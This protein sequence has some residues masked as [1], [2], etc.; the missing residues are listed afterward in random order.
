MSD[1]TYLENYE[2]LGYKVIPIDKN[3]SPVL[4]VGKTVVRIG[5]LSAPDAYKDFTNPKVTHGAV[6]CGSMFCKLD[7]NVCRKDK[8]CGSGIVVIDFDKF[9]DKHDKDTFFC[10]AKALEILVDNEF[11]YTPED[12]SSLPFPLLKTRSGG[13]HAWFKY[14]DS[15][16]PG[17]NRAKS[18]VLFYEKKPLIDIKSSH[19]YA[20]VPISG[21]SD[22]KWIVSPWDD[23]FKEEGL[24]TL[25]KV[26]PSLY[27]TLI[28][29]NDKKEENEEVEVDK[30]VEN[31]PPPKAPI[32]AII[33][34]LSGLPQMTID[35]REDYLRISMSI[36]ST[37]REEGKPAFNHLWEA[38]SFTHADN[39][40]T[41]WQGFLKSTSGKKP[42]LGGL[43]YV[44]KRDAPHLL[45]KFTFGKWR[46]P[47]NKDE[48][49]NS[50]LLFRGPESQ[51]TYFASQLSGELYYIPT[52]RK[53]LVWDEMTFLWNEL[54]EK[55]IRVYVSRFAKKRIS[56]YINLM[57]TDKEKDNKKDRKYLLTLKEKYEHISVVAEI[58]SFMTYSLMD[59]EITKKLNQAP[60]LLPLPGKMLVELKTSTIRLRTPKDLFTKT[61]SVKPRPWRHSKDFKN[62]INMLFPDKKEREYVRRVC[63]SILTL[64]FVKIMPVF[65][66]V[67]NTLKSTFSDMISQILDGFSTTLEDRAILFSEKIRSASGHNQALWNLKGSRM[68]SYS[69]IGPKDKLSSRG[70][71]ECISGENV[72]ASCKF[73]ST[74]KF[75][76]KAKFVCSTNIMPNY[77]VTDK[78]VDI[79]LRII[80]FRNVVKPNSK[81]RDKIYGLLPELLSWMIDGA[82]E[83]YE[84][85]M[86][87]D[88][89]PFLDRK[90]QEKADQDILAHFLD[91]GYVLTP[92]VDDG[93]IK[94]SELWSEFISYAKEREDTTYSNITFGKELKA[95]GFTDIKSDGYWY[96]VGIAESPGTISVP[97]K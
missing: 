86:N 45:S 89:D 31:N 76:I 97:P 5:Y 3:R 58:V 29:K 70:A 13:Y 52:T 15:L 90:N 14:D 46:L 22:Y 12:F 9:K 63:G 2:K 38:Y 59:T 36:A 69:E 37:Y 42:S 21:N 25:R 30:Y 26:F 43:I 92:G 39:K 48:R 80:E 1:P 66:G 23:K 78:G 16:K 20:T 71:K 94:K 68:C 50:N 10:G 88:D 74:E 83:A 91:D 75:I 40:A 79:R 4:T 56:E 55:L 73:G 72:S 11:N 84:K 53:W 87:F 81:E 96:W 44:V 17:T 24:P 51:A 49:G 28:K 47:F 77:S 6:I 62:F 67:P 82:K 64:E 93:R 95:R 54:D 60:D 35:S 65:L 61:V 8:K 19:N 33:D 7:A 41:A 57:E 32:E 34:V 18:G 85:D 27:S